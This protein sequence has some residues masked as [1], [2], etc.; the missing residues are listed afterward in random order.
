MVYG[1]KVVGIVEYG[2]KAYGRVELGLMIKAIID[3]I[4]VKCSKTILSL[5][6]G[7]LEHGK[8]VI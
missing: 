8:S 4:R 1:I 7:Y 2:K 3:G 5:L 6:I